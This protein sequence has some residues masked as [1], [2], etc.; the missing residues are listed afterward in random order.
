MKKTFADRW[1]WFVSHVGLPLVILVCIW[2]C[3]SF[4]TRYPFYYWEIW[5][6][7]GLAVANVFCVLLYFLYVLFCVACMIKLLKRHENWKFYLNIQLLLLPLVSLI[8]PMYNQYFLSYINSP[9]AMEMVLLSFVLLYVVEFCI[10]GLPTMLILKKYSFGGEPDGQGDADRAPSE[11]FEST[12][13]NDEPSANSED[14]STL[15]CPQCGTR[16]MDGAC[17]CHVCGYKKS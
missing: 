14:A 12:Y 1:Y 16:M 9:Y 13:V 7:I 8:L 5:N 10:L 15:Y 4:I 11:V 6:Y 2:M 17:F 3:V